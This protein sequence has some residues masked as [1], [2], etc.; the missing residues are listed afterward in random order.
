MSNDIIVDWLGQS[1]ITYR[2]W[3]LDDPRNPAAIRDEGGNYAF[4]K[5]LATGNFVPLRFG[6]THSL[7]GRVPGHECWADAARL[8]ATH[9][10][11][12]QGV[13]SLGT[14]PNCYAFCSDCGR[15]P[16]QKADL[17]AGPQEPPEAA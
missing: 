5:Q 2:Y 16:S 6:E 15:L 10:M 13:S 14:A 8:G 12:L 17:A 9:V 4:V 1:G 7:R 11:T 3:V